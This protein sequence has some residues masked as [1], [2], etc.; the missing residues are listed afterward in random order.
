MMQMRA[1]T[2]AVTYTINDH[3]HGRFPVY[4]SH[5]KS[6]VVINSHLSPAINVSEPV[7]VEKTYM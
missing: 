4:T 2:L 1:S 5:S 3:L 7:S 6:R